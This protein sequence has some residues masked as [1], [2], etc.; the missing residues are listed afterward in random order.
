VDDI[1]VAGTL[2]PPRSRRLIADLLDAADA[3]RHRRGAS[4]S[5]VQGRAFCTSALLHIGEGLMSHWKAF[6]LTIFV[7]IGLLGETAGSAYA[8]CI[9]SSEQPLCATEWSSGGPINLGGPPGFTTSAAAGINDAGQVV[10]YSLVGNGSYATEWSG[11]S[12][13]NL[14]GLSGSTSSG[15][16]G[17][18]DAR[19]GGR[20]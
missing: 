11:G 2:R 1:S 12:S 19:A 17:I 20:I 15:A 10:G 13:I 16:R 5:F 6:G 4:N 9:R 14:G 7:V 3:A 18:N 8:Q